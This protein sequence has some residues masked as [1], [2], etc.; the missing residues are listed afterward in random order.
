MID[1]D[2]FSGDTAEV[3]MRFVHACEHHDYTRVVRMPTE[4]AFNDNLTTSCPADGLT[5]VIA[6]RVNNMV[7][8]C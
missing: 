7:S 3:H 6:M 2:S 4:L 5:M 1:P 8:A